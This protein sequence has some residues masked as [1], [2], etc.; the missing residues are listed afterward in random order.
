LPEAPKLADGNIQ[1]KAGDQRQTG[2]LRIYLYVGTAQ[3]KGT[4]QQFL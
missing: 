4:A 3:K 2:G 1:S